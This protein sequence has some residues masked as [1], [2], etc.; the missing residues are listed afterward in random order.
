MGPY[1]YA[2]GT[3]FAAPLVSGVVALMLEANASLGSRD[4]QEILALS[5]RTVGLGL[6]DVTENGAATVNGGGFATSREAGFGLV[7]AHA[8]VRMAESW[9]GG[10]SF[11][12]AAVIDIAAGTGSDTDLSDNAALLRFAAGDAVQKVEWIELR[13]TLD[14]SFAGDL[15]IA[16]ISPDG[17]RSLLL[18][19]PNRGQN[20]TNDL[21]FTLSSAQFRG[22][23]AAG[24]WQLEVLDADGNGIGG[25]VAAS[26]RLLGSAG[27]NSVYAFTDEAGQRRATA[28]IDDARGHDVINAAALTTA[29]TIDLATGG[30]SRIA[31]QSVTLAATT[32]LEDAIGGAGD[33]RLSGNAVANRLQ[34]GA[35][36]DVFDG[37]G[38]R[39][40]ISG[41]NGDDILD[42][43]ATRASVSLLATA[44]RDSLRID[45][46]MGSVILDGVET[47][48][49]TDGAVAVAD[50]LAAA[51]TADAGD[52]VVNLRAVTQTDA[53]GATIGDVRF[54]AATSAEY[55]LV[56]DAG[57]LF[58]IDAV[59]G[60]I[61]LIDTA[62][63]AGRSSAQIIV[64]GVSGADTFLK[65]IAIRLPQ[66]VVT[67]TEP[68][69]N[70][71]MAWLR[72]SK[73]NDSITGTGAAERIEALAGHDRVRAGGG[74]DVLI[75]GKGKD[76]LDGG[77]GRDT[78]SFRGA[79][80]VD[81][82][83]SSGK[84][85][86]GEA[87]GDRFLSIET[88]AFGDNA[89]RFIGSGKS[90]SVFMGGGRDRAFGG[91]GHDRLSGGKGN[92]TLTGGEGAD[93]F[94]FDS[95]RGTDIVVD[96]NAAEGDRFIIDAGVFGLEPGKA[97][98]N[99][100]FMV[101]DDLAA[102]GK[103]PTILFD[104]D[105]GFVLFDRD[106][107]GATSAVTLA[108]VSAGMVLTAADFAFI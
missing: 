66:P 10:A 82:S 9:T 75:G 22:E 96:F 52:A 90:E 5:A 46:A 50:L 42:I 76:V 17:T 29:V 63:F 98:A 95:R 65:S 79:A 106:G 94:I 14:H 88:F 89:D 80:T 67:P 102:I 83:V 77:A 25:T 45:Y 34:G 33:D 18:D 38:G 99:L 81:L 69:P 60:L 21:S 20:A 71:E 68:L 31:G 93:S 78:A 85:N 12:S 2:T 91:G 35:G 40:I 7:D 6:T 4:V 70:V 49:F 54:A 107:A 16:L 3:S 47:L 23:A 105:E 61:T 72:G 58:T 15:K 24:E 55:R 56:D 41:G 84:A 59:T 87:R 8:A 44:A 27:S 39:D 104:S 57:G 32:V 64:E 48:R 37:R 26:L 19:Q 92:D 74:D 73:R 100:A 51:A 43:A 62:G 97:A 1:S 103:S 28:S 53:A 30:I 11:S 101:G 13:L 108:Q 36:N 86:S